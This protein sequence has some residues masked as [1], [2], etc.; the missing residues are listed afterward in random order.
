MR[1]D[2]VV[3]VRPAAQSAPAGDHSFELAF[4]PPRAAL[5][6]ACDAE[7]HGAWVEALKVA[8]R[9]KPLQRSASAAAPARLHEDAGALRKQL[10]V[11]RAVANADAEKTRQPQLED[12]D[13]AGRR[14]F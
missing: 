5:A 4:A 11:F 9:E 10:E 8:R 7:R 2:E 14:A 3:A 12:A 6:F 1:L 13:C